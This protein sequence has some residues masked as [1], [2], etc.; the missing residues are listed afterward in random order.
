M[1]YQQNQRIEV[2]VR[3]DDGGASLQGANEIL[4]EKNAGGGGGEG[5]RGGWIAALTGSTSIKRQNR[6]FKTNATH[7][8]AVSK[9]ILLLQRNYAI[10]AI[11]YRNGDQALQDAVQRQV[12]IVED[13]GNVASSV[14]MG[15][16]YGSWGGPLGTVLGL[17]FAAVGTGASLAVKYGQREREYNVKLF[18][19]YNGISYMRARSQ[20]NLT[21]GRLR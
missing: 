1:L 16:L 8:L 5:Q 9:Q 4:P 10:G 20:I 11:G 15:A 21:T 3:K 12:E 13:I 6:V 18:K 17:G 19:E 14:S 2:V 7:A